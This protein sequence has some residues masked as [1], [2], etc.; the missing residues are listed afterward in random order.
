M[1]FYY[2]VRGK[3]I[4]RLVFSFVC[5]CV[6]IYSIELFWV[7]IYFYVIFFFLILNWLF[8]ITVVYLLWRFV[9]WLFCFG[10]GFVLFYFNSTHLYTSKIKKEVNKPSVKLLVAWW[11]IFL[12][13]FLK[14][15]SAMQLN[16][17]SN[18]DDIITGKEVEI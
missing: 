16:T 3:Y 8:V 7:E 12:V 6:S 15:W 11:C 10:F 18:D 5:M 9:I 4:F 17:Q 2:Y 1:S 14:V 13:S